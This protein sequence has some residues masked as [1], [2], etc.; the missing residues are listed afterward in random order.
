MVLPLAWLRCYVLALMCALLWPLA[1]GAQEAQK[2]NLSP[3]FVQISDAMGAA[4]A[5]DEA[6]ARQHVEAVHADFQTLPGE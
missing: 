6:Q 3:L 1:A 5:G 4:K 2:P